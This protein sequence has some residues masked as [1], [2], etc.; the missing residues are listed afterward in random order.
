MSEVCAA[1]GIVNL[2]V[3][4]MYLIK[5]RN[6]Y[7]HYK[8]QLADVKGVK[9]FEYID[10]DNPEE[11]FNVR[12]YQYIVIEVDDKK[13]DVNRNALLKLLRLKAVLARRYFYPGCHKNPPYDKQ[14]HRPLLNTEAL[15]QRVLCLP[16]G[17]AINFADIDRVCNIIRIT[18]GSK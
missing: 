1:M 16:T 10:D 4:N 3:I 2:D 7:Y 18:C 12:N 5:N 9:L 8:E 6:N 14:I 11:S 13:A 17:D 15:A